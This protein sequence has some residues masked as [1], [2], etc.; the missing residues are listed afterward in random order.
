MEIPNDIT[1]SEAKSS[2]FHESLHYLVARYQA[3]T[4]RKFL[5]VFE[6]KGLS[7]VERY[8]VERAYHERAVE[9][10]IDKLLVHDPD[11][12]FENR[13]G[14]YCINNNYMELVKT[15]SAIVFGLLVYTSLVLPI[16]SPTLL[17]PGRIKDY[18]LGRYKGSMRDKL[19]GPIE[20]PQFK[21]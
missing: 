4:G 11:A 5:D 2:T 3:D 1:P 8:Q 13:W 9:L 16:L 21:I 18:V 15:A 7:R 19:M 17:I 20:Y 10:L 12:Q 6:R 14:D